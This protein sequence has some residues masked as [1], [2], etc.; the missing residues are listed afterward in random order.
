MQRGKVCKDAKKLCFFANFAPLRETY[1][2]RP[3][4]MTL[5]YG[6]LLKPW[7]LTPMA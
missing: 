5:P 6:T 3:N 1:L 7:L 4:L 2:L